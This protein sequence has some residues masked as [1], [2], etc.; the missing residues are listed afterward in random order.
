MYNLT[1]GKMDAEQLSMSDSFGLEETLQ[2]FPKRKVAVVGAG[3]S[4]LSVAYLLTQTFSTLD[5]TIFAENTSPNTTSDVASAILFPN[6]LESESAEEYVLNEKRWFESTYKR[7]CD[8]IHSGEEGRAGVNLASGY[9]VNMDDASSQQNQSP[10][11]PWFKNSVMGFR[12]VPEWEKKFHNLPSS[13]SA[14]FF[15][16]VAVDC[17]LYLPW[18]MDKF[19]ESGGSFVQKKIV[20]FDD[21]QRD[22]SVVI[23][24]TGLA[25]RELCQDSSIYPIYGQSL[26]VDAPWIKH[27]VV[28]P[29]YQANEYTL[30]LPRVKDVLIGGVFRSHRETCEVDSVLSEQIMTKAVKVVPS[31]AGVNVLG[32]APGLRPVRSRIRLEVEHTTRGPVVHNYGHGGNGVNYSWGCAQDVCGLVQGLGLC[33]PSCKL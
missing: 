10:P 11:E 24:C 29:H 19:I 32:V 8:V 26:M 12:N 5:V 16:T 18:L 15:T 2:M 17:R 20:S 4:G 3:V 22:Y 25:S 21:L 1:H 33:G 7:F 27:F 6:P 30:V 31:L 23:N 14:M 28:M 13:T 9:Y